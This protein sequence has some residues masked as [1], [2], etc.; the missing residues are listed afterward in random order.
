MNLLVR[1]T[2]VFKRRVV[3]GEVLAGTE[4]PAGGVGVGVIPN[5]TKLPKTAVTTLR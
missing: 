4:V 2:L 3:S 1:S 5:G